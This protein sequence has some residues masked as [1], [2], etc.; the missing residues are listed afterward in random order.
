MLGGKGR[1]SIDDIQFGFMPGK[2]TTD[3]IFNMRQHQER[4]QARKKNL[5]YVF[6]DFEMLRWASR[7]LGLDDTTDI[8]VG[9]WH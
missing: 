7:K 1:V 2:G 4:H 8:V 9:R 6:L 3:V 5:Y